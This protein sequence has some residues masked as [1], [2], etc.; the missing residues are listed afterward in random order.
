MDGL[1]LWMR[2]ENFSCETKQLMNLLS[3]I[4]LLY[5]TLFTAM[6]KKTSN[7]QTMN[8]VSF[9]M[10]RAEE[11]LHLPNQKVSG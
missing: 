1:L 11:S 10:A 4:N 2:V 8:Y 3:L 7:C 9:S 5:I 6:C